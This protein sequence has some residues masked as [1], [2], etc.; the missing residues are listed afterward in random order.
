MTQAALA[1]VD[2]DS[3]GRMVLA[4]LA[5]LWVTRDRAAILEKLLA[6]QG[7]LPPDAIDAFTPAGAFAE[8]LT[9]MRDQLMGQVLSAPLLADS[10]KVE[11]IIAWAGLPPSGPSA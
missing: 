4:L 7:V 11:D 1:P 2:V 8:Q 10:P 6:D 9:Q 3:L 5:E